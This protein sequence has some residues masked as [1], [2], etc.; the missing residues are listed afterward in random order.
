MERC[1]NKFTSRFNEGRCT[2]DTIN[3]ID[4]LLKHMV[5]KT[6]TYEKLTQ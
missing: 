1:I 6:M 2:V 3:R 5:G 4:A